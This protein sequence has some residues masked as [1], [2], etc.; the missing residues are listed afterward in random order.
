LGRTS[1]YSD[2][3]PIGSED[4]D[5]L[6]GSTLEDMPERR[7]TRRV[8]PGAGATNFETAQERTLTKQEGS[9]LEKTDGVESDSNSK[10]TILLIDDDVNIRNLLQHYIKKQGYDVQAVDDGVNALLILGKQKFDLIISDI[11]MPNL[12]GVKLLKIMKQHKIDVPLIFLTARNE[13]KYEVECLEL[14]AADYIVKP[15]KFPVLKL[16]MKRILGEM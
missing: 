12:D 16:R 8:V 11:N 2:S 5:S 4:S 9:S 15:I 14:G 10:K 1:A 13:E 7:R 6:S 3:E